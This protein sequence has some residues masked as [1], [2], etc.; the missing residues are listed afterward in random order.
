MSKKTHIYHP[1]SYPFC[2]FV[3][4]VFVTYFTNLRVHVFS[5]CTLSTILYIYLCNACALTPSLPHPPSI[6]ASNVRRIMVE[7][8][9]GKS[10]LMQDP[11]ELS[12]LAFPAC[13]AQ[14]QGRVHILLMTTIVKMK[15]N[16]DKYIHR[17]LLWK[18]GLQA[19]VF[20]L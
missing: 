11:D 10:N 5:L 8:T 14:T 15:L 3:F 12:A 18:E 9:G 1:F 19:L 16:Y 7:N 2:H 13:S 6:A 17:S 20:S 4:F